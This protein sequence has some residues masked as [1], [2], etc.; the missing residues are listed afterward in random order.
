MIRWLVSCLWSCGQCSTTR[1]YVCFPSVPSRL[2]FPVTPASLGLSLMKCSDVKLI[3][4]RKVWQRLIHQFWY[5]L[6]VSTL[7]KAWMNSYFPSL[8]EAQASG[9]EKI[10]TAIHCIFAPLSINC[11]NIFFCLLRFLS[12]YICPWYISVKYYIIFVKCMKYTWIIF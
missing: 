4:V 3:I 8:F 7:R 5:P 6:L 1:L 12:C 2:P 11:L 9:V 10:R